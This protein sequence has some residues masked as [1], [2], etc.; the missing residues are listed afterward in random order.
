MCCINIITRP[1]ANSAAE[2][3]RKKKVSDSMLTLSY[4]KPINKT[5]IYKDIHINS[6]V[7]NKCKAVLTLRTIVRK[8]MKN[9]IKT[10]FKSPNTITL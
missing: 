7:N 9:R 4:I 3:I 10:R 5:I 8:K 6:A 2:N 1:K